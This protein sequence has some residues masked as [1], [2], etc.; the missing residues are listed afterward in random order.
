[1][2]LTVLLLL[3]L[4]AT[5]GETSSPRIEVSDI[6]LV[7][8]ISADTQCDQDVSSK[9]EFPRTKLYRSESDPPLPSSIPAAS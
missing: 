5:W 8:P 7:Q 6:W 3:S 1:M 4:G 9:Y 2:S